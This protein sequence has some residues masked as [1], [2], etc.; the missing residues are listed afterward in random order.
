MKFKAG[1]RVRVVDEGIAKDYGSDVM[2]GDTGTATGDSAGKFSIT[3]IMDNDRSPNPKMPWYIPS[4][5]LE[6]IK[7]DK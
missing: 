3:V 7:E 4:S 2:Y 1:T 5:T 6:E